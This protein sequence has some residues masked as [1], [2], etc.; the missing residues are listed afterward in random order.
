[1]SLISVFNNSVNNVI[2]YVDEQLIKNANKNP[3]E[4][5]VFLQ[6]MIPLFIIIQFFL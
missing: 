1:M 6:L 4:N 2:I 5:A 3:I